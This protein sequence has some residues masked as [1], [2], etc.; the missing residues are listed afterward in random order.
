M[1]I[2]SN[3]LLFCYMH[4][5][6]ISSSSVSVTYKYAGCTNKGDTTT[7]DFTLSTH[8]KCWD[9][10]MKESYVDSKMTSFFFCFTLIYSYRRKTVP[11]TRFWHPFICESLCQSSLTLAEMQKGLDTWR[12]WWRWRRRQWWWWWWKNCYPHLPCLLSTNRSDSDIDFSGEHDYIWPLECK[13]NNL[14]G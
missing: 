8:P 9:L 4:K 3:S 5:T 11:E 2:T 12:W 6:T 14:Q 1:K 7:R 10:T 13:M